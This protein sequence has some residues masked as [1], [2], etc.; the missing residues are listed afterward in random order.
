MNAALGVIALFVVGA[1]GLAV[2]ARRGRTMSLEQW[3]S[4]GAGWEPSWCSC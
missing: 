1:L 2:L 3:A 4:A